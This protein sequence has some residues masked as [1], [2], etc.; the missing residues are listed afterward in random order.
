MK[1][2]VKVPKHLLAGW[3]EHFKKNV[4][5]DK[6]PEILRL[7][8]GLPPIPREHI[9]GRVRLSK[10]LPWLRNKHNP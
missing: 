4:P 6:W 7:S 10:R 2:E 9:N 1:H 5:Q 8:E 3:S